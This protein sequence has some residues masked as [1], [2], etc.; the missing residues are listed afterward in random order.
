MEFLLQIFL[1]FFLQVVVGVITDVVLHARVSRRLDLTLISA[2]L[3]AF[4]K[5]T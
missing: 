5:R 3:T 1:E 2:R 4:G